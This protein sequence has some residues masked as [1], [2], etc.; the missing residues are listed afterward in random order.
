MVEYL[1]PLS[2]LY[3]DI[4]ASNKNTIS[5]NLDIFVLIGLVELQFSFSQVLILDV[6]T[7]SVVYDPS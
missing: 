6:L 2:S 4:V 5:Y 1:W 3:T 7:V